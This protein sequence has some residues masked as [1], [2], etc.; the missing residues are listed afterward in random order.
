[1]PKRPPKPEPIT[2]EEVMDSPA[3]AG[4]DTFLRS[5]G[6]P[7]AETP[8]GDSPGGKPAAS[9]RGDLPQGESPPGQQATAQIPSVRPVVAEVPRG[10][11]PR[12]ALRAEDGHSRGEQALYQALWKAAAGDGEERLIRAG[13]GAMSRLCGLDP[14]NCKDNLRSLTAKL[15]V[16]VAEP[17]RPERGEGAVYRVFGP[18]AIVRRRR[19]AGLEWVLVRGQGV[20]FVRAGAPATPVPEPAP[21]GPEAGDGTAAVAAESVVQTHLEL[22]DPPAHGEPS[23]PGRR[24]PR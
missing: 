7:R 17:P 13:Y 4:F 9:P 5:L 16:E 1:M 6:D 12:R 20:A 23:T 10:P 19:Q 3:L 2:P 24:T 15:A 21:D 14:S 11:R 22:P 18:E 8:Q